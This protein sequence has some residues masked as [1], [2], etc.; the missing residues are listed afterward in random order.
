ML[1][2]F[3]E[4]FIIKLVMIIIILTILTWLGPQRGIYI[5]LYHAKPQKAHC[6]HSHPFEQM[7]TWELTDKKTRITNLQYSHTYC[8]YHKRYP[9]AGGYLM[10][11]SESVS[12]LGSSQIATYSMN[13]RLGKA[14]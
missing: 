3:L 4:E 5:Q 8:H 2:L 6:N 12:K 10:L 11:H 1:I 9:G 13:W 7:V 14:G